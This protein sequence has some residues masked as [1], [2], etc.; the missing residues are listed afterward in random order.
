MRM[1]EIIRLHPPVPVGDYVV[2][3][4]APLDKQAVVDSGAGPVTV[5]REQRRAMDVDAPPPF[6]DAELTA[7]DAAV[8]YIKEDADA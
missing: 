5:A 4:Y 3:G 1:T 6:S 7:I 2:L 8:K